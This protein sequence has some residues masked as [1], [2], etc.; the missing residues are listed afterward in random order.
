MTEFFRRLLSS[1]FMPHGGC[2]FWRPDILWLH[3]ASDALIALSYF[4]IPFSLVQL[5]RKRHDLEFDWMFVLFGVFILACGLTHVLQIWNIWHSAY[6]LEGLVKAITGVAS[7]VTAILMFRLVPKAL[8]LASPARLQRE[9]AER[10][11]AQD[12][13][14]SLNAKLEERVEQRTAM[15]TRSNEALQRFAYIAS[16][17]LQEPIRTVRSLNQLL[18]RDYKGRLDERADRYLYFI[19]DASDRM[20]TLVKDLLSYSKT[21]DQSNRSLEPANATAVLSHA[22]QD[23][24]VAIEESSGII[25]HDELPEVLIDATHLEQIFSNLLSNAL[26]YRKPGT[27]ARVF[28]KAERQRAECVFSVSDQG[29]GIE[30]RYFDQIFVAFRRLHGREFPGSGVGLTICKNLVEEYGGQI[31]VNSAP[32]EGA[33]FSF[34]L[35]AAES[36]HAM[37]S[38]VVN[39][40]LNVR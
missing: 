2:Y 34:T 28:V 31:W 37:A 17:D 39:G 20:Q 6:R 8:A 32:G 36:W 33:T 23:L 5:V 30:P 12:E 16:H 14:R 35:P 40:D 4:L 7:V 1:D 22:I 29:V 9:I 25:E 18:A 27:P 15:L 10:K 13:A 19:L 21:L 38:S 26:K 3:A 11:E 24:S